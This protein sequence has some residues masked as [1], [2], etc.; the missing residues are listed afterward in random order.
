MNSAVLVRRDSA[1]A[2][3]AVARLTRPRVQRL[4]WPSH[5]VSPQKAS[6]RSRPEASSFWPYRQYEEITMTVDSPLHADCAKC[7]GLCCVAPAFDADQGFGFDKPAHTACRNLDADHRCAIHAALRVQGF[8][9]CAAFDCYG[10]GQW[11]TQ[12]LFGGRS[13]RTSPE[14]A[15]RMF[16]LYGTV[17]VLHELMV[18]LELAIGRVSPADAAPLARC[19]FDI[20]NICAAGHELIDTFSESALRERVRGLLRER[21]GSRAP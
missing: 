4:G 15:A 3:V 1:R 19:L 13:W 17:R 12:H 7:C 16:T 21:L 14:L 9:A 8:P 18:L 10:A 11:V 2:R 6:R 20:Q 5:L